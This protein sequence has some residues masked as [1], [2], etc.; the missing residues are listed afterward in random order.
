M[1][2]VVLG[3]LAALTAV[4]SSVSGADAQSTTT[5]PGASTSS[6]A[7]TSTTAPPPSPSTEPPASTPDT[8]APPPDPGAGPEGEDTSS[9]EDPLVGEAPAEPAPDTD[10]TVPPPDGSY[11]GQGSFEPSPVL[12]SSVRSAENKLADTE[13]RLATAVDELYN[14]RLKVKELNV[15]RE[16]LRG[17]QL[18]ALAEL[19]EAEEVLTNRSIAAFVGADT[20]AE[21]VVGLLQAADH[22]RRIDNW[23][24][25]R[26]LSVALDQDD[27]A[28]EDYR[29]LRQD[30][31]QDVVATAEAIRRVE[32]RAAGAEAE[33]EAIVAER[34][35]AADELEAFAAGSAIYISG[36]RFPVAWPYDTPLI[37]SWGFP[38]MPGTPDEH[39]HEGIDLF[40]PAGTPLVAAERGVI[41]KISTGRLGGL[42]FWLRGESGAEW[43]Y[44]HLQSY[45]DGLHVGQVVE[46]GQVLGF[47]GNTGNAVGTPPHLHLQLH[48]DGGDPVNPYPLLHVTS[49]RDLAAM[50]GED[51]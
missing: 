43:Y 38:R 23:T 8:T 21:A 22:D 12:W 15:R 29:R 19:E 40:A 24:K 13:D 2:V 25:S 34:E 36:V 46:A 50:N 14:A 4:L 41:I 5:D 3:A 35:A 18:D 45:A 28:I 31:D 51:G 11:G 47:V 33:A 20:E 26:L 49:Q 17:D 10:V 39:W 32:R 9:T 16:G 6:S 37:D 30:L 42:T 1:R 48:P 7:S 27:E 44:A